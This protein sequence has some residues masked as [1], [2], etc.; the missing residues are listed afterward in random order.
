M[1]LRSSGLGAVSSISTSQSLLFISP[2]I[3]ISLSSE[4]KMPVTYRHILRL[5]LKIDSSL[6]MFLR[7]SKLPFFFF[8]YCSTKSMFGT[9]MA[10]FYPLHWSIA[11]TNFYE[12][13]S[14]SP[15]EKPIISS[16]S[17]FTL[18]WLRADAMNSLMWTPL[19]ALTST[20]FTSS[21]ALFPFLKHPS[22]LRLSAA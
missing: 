1:R 5:T 8:P 2:G 19:G 13:C 9:T 6:A 4:L 12:S 10:M 18:F 20:P 15:S 21:S 7:S 16:S 11:S 22:S 17:R 3:S 14:I